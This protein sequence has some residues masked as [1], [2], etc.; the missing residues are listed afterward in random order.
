MLAESNEPFE[1]IVLKFLSITDDRRNGLKRFL[2]LKL[3][4]MNTRE[5]F[6]DSFWINLL[7]IYLHVSNIITV[8]FLENNDYEYERNLY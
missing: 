7:D 4:S 5:V 2:D 1:V 6:F 8:L 3:N